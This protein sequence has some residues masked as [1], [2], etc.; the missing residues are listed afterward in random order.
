M[1]VFLQ[2]IKS[3]ASI[4]NVCESR[5]PTRAVN[6]TASKDLIRP[7]AFHK[8]IASLEKTLATSV[9]FDRIRSD[10]IKLRFTEVETPKAMKA[11]LDRLEPL[12]AAAGWWKLE[13]VYNPAA[14]TLSLDF[15]R[16]KPE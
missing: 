14:K 2:R 12:V 6:V 13:A 7:N 16:N 10:S 5:F 4:Q 1:N 11:S 15:T 3:S 9:Q 8:L